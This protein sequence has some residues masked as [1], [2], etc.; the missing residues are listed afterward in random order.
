MKKI[1]TLCTVAAITIVIGWGACEF[2]KGWREF[3]VSSAD[4]DDNYYHGY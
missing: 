2:I 4:D 1:A 3:I